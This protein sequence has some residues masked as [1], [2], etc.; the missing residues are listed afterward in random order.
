MMR[1]SETPGKG[2]TVPDVFIHSRFDETFERYPLVL[3]DVGARGGPRSHWTPARRHLRFLG[4]EPDPREFARLSGITAAAKTSDRYFNTALHN[5]RG[6]VRLH[7][8]RDG[9]LSSIF[10]PNREF[11]DT[12]PDASRFDT[13][14]TIDVPTDTLDDVLAAGGIGDVDFVK[15]DTQG[16]ELYVLEGG[17]GLLERA[18]IGVEVEVEFAPI[19]TDQP[20]FADV[21]RLLQRLGFSLFDLRPVYWKREVGRAVGGPRGQVV[22]A[23]ALYLK[24][25]PALR[26]M[27]AA[28]EPTFGRSKL[29]RAIA[30]ALLYGYFDYAL[31]IARQAG[32]VLTADDRRTI[33]RHVRTAG[34]PRQL[35]ANFPGRKQLALASRRL[36]KLL[37]RR[38]DAW[39]VSGAKLGN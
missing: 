10:R 36:W 19:Y 25:L 26:T 35:L 38:D 11:I 24:S 7:V 23:D 3:V 20:L 33:D 34:A 31:E 22:W 2:L 16:S 21:D 12:F 15:A 37:A 6:T 18:V 5:R 27:T 13:L 29:L 39:S 28:A 4:F 1:G 14:E 17:A 8:A 30:V 9:G 32:E